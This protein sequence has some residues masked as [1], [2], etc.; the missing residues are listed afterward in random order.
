MR[1]I[2]VYQ[3]CSTD[4]HKTLVR[5][6]YEDFKVEDILKDLFNKIN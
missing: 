4:G 1:I 2:T 6:N 3:N 5:E